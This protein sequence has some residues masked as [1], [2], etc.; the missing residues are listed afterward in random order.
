M[1]N[2]RM[3]MC[4]AG[5]A[6]M[7][8]CSVTAQAKESVEVPEQVIIISEELGERYNISPELIQAICWRE[9]RFQTDAEDRGCIGIMQV[10]A[11]WHR[12]RMERLG[13]TDLYDMRQCMTVAVDYL[14]ELAQG[15]DVAE[16]LS[17]YHGESQVQE[18]MERG[19]L[20]GYVETILEVAADLERR[21]GK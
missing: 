13:V 4:A 3:R 19:E 9:S 11:K 21:N 12:G 2:T 18:R 17:I 14:A 10:Y 1:R 6:V 15:T 20:S 5:V 7:L 16:A 8:M